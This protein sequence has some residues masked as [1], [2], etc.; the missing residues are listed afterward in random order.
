MCRS[1]LETGAGRG[2][3]SEGWAAFHSTNQN[4]ATCLGLVPMRA[5]YIWSW[6]FIPVVF[7]VN[8]NMSRTWGP[9]DALPACSP[10]RNEGLCTAAEFTL[11]LKRVLFWQILKKSH[12][13]CR[14]ALTVKAWSG[15]GSWFLTL[16]YRGVRGNHR[17]P[18]QHVHVVGEGKAN[19]IAQSEAP[20]PHPQLF[21]DLPQIQVIDGSNISPYSSISCSVSFVKAFFP[22]PSQLPS[23]CCLCALY[24]STLY[25]LK[26]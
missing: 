24:F 21:Q 17:L 4:L 11:K 22:S 3:C 26:D 13:N 15:F 6:E 10:C 23:P 5:P 8:G 12:V 9:E 16:L 19:T 2:I 18:F 20:H 1:E 25:F 14:S 7:S